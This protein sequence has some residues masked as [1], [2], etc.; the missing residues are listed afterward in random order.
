MDS[1]SRARP[2][3]ARGCAVDPDFRGQLGR[4]ARRGNVPSR[5]PGET[6]NERDDVLGPLAD[7][8]HCDGRL[9]YDNAEVGLESQ[10]RALRPPRI[11]RSARAAS[12][13]GCSRDAEESNA[14]SAGSAVPG[15]AST[16][17]PL[18]GRAASFQWKTP[19]DL[20]AKSKRRA[21]ESGMIGN[22]HR[23]PAFD[24]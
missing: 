15:A 17:C 7:Q 21:S 4:L 23:T 2:C 20:A 24:V 12:M 9:R 1:P 11:A 5:R 13:A 8:S 6:P 18:H 16:E 19:A 10:R 3:R 14:E 22:R